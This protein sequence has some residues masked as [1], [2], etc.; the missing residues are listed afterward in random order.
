MAEIEDAAVVQAGG[1]VSRR[2]KLEPLLADGPPLQLSRGKSSE[3]DHRQAQRE[4][5]PSDSK[6]LPAP[7][8]INLVGRESDHQNQRQVVDP[9]EE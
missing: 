9:Q 3:P 2:Q 1:C 7:V 4:R 8:G 6:G 5:N